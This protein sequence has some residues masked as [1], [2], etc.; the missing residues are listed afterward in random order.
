MRFLINNTDNKVINIDKLTY[1]GN[2][3]SLSEIAKDESYAFLQEDICNKEAIKKNIP[4]IS[5]R[6]SYAFNCRISC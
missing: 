2:L 1:A 3:E 6:C 5:P 4:Q